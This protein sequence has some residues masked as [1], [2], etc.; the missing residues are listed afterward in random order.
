[1]AHHRA[2][3]IK[4]AEQ[5]YK[6]A[7]AAKPGDPAALHLLGLAAFDRGRPERALQL[8]A[9]ALERAP[10]HPDYL[11]S[12]GHVL[13]ATGQT[14]AAMDRYRAALDADPSRALTR[15]NLGNVLKRAGRLDEAVA[16][17]ARA[18]EIEPGFAEGW[19]NLGLA[20]KERRN[21]DVALA[22][23][24]R[25]EALDPTVAAFPYNAANTLAAA[26]RRDEAI[27]VFHR[28]L[29][30]A[31][32]HP[33]AIANLGAPLRQSGQ[34]D[35]ALDV[36]EGGRILA[37]NNAELR[38][39]LG[40]TRLMAGQWKLGF[41]NFEARRDIPG[42]SA[43]PIKGTLWDGRPV[44]GRTLLIAHEQGFGDA[45]Q[46]LCFARDAEK[47]G[48]RVIYRG[49]KALLV[50]ARKI[51]GI[52]AAVAQEDPLPRFDYW[53]PMMRLPHV[54]KATSAQKLER[55]GYLAPATERMGLWRQRLAG[56]GGCR[57]G[58][59]WQGNP[60][61]AADAERSIPLNHFVAL[62]GLPGV[63]LISLQKGAGAEQL[64]GWP[65]GTPAPRDLGAEI[66]T[67]GNAF[68]DTAAILPLLDVVV[69]SDSA[70]AHLAGAIGVPTFMA[71]P[72][73]PDWRWG[74]EGERTVWYPTLHVFR[75]RQRG[76]WDQ[77]FGDIR[78]ALGARI[79]VHG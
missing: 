68:M 23:F 51:S 14:D 71:L 30:I 26:G 27:Q 32:D 21:F 36:L 15:S 7:L 44:P 59:G 43:P 67:D 9:K 47:L 79:G 2:G 25:A 10:A 24:A 65:A 46:F 58:I 37:P 55:G 11:H 39:N 49:P 33:G 74:L 53:L 61:Y 17:L 18:V 60:G 70:L 16:E 56:N 29:T 50:M 34:L 62:A 73:V 77:V 28:V 19:S 6:R 40:L 69:T 4:K 41:E 13:Q 66:D 57:I 35:M 20:E 38:W 63:E 75:Q 78:E 1:M 8:I 12:A 54:L 5:N 45:I 42:M 64:A 3:N 22:A 31:P 76:D 48:A 52:A 72:Q